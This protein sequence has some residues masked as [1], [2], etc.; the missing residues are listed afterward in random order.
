MG[1]WVAANTPPPGP[2]RTEMIPRDWAIRTA[3]LKV[4]TDTSQRARSSSLEPS[5]SPEA[6]A[7]A[8]AMSSA[9]ADSPRDNRG[10]GRT[11]A[12]W[13]RRHSWGRSAG[14]SKPVSSPVPLIVPSVAALHNSL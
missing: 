13:G 9:A 3:S 7:S 2:G 4:P 8:M 14:V 5:R 12:G 1:D 11:S 6:A 10:P